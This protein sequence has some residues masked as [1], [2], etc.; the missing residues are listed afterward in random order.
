MKGAWE[1]V[2]EGAYCGTLIYSIVVFIKLKRLQ[3]QGLIKWECWQGHVVSLLV[4]RGASVVLP[5]P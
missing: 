2:A 3:G 4:E 1:N 5:F